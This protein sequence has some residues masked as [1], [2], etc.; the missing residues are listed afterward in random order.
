MNVL[1]AIAL[2]EVAGVNICA[3]KVRR[4]QK[5]VNVNQDHELIL[6]QK[7][8]RTSELHIVF[9]HRSWAPEDPLVQV[10]CYNSHCA[11]LLP[12]CGKA[13]CSA[14]DRER[15]TEREPVA[16]GC[17]GLA[18]KEPRDVASPGQDQGWSQR[19][20]SQTD[21]CCSAA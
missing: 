12:G 7:I 19:S 5:G 4:D 6:P 17:C 20:G 9:L 8:C 18:S 2:V 21:R 3:C 1:L 15:G 14:R 16:G 10:W 11:P 13:G